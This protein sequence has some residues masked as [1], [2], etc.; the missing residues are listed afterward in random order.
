MSLDEIQ[1]VLEIRLAQL[2]VA[3]EDLDQEPAEKPADRE[4]FQ[5]RNE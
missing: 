2:D 5:P 4:D 1:E 3:P